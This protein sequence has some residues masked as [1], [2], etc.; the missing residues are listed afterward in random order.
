MPRQPRVRY[1]AAMHQKGSTVYSW[2]WCA[3]SW[4]PGSHALGAR[5]RGEG[6]TFPLCP[7]RWS[8]LRCAPAGVALGWHGAAP[9]RRKGAALRESEV[10]SR[11]ASG[12]ATGEGEMT[13]RVARSLSV[14]PHGDNSSGKLRRFPAGLGGR[15]GDGALSGLRTRS[16]AES[17]PLPAPFLSARISVN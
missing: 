3:I 11:A 4:F 16:A 6:P 15:A 2:L 1:P 8:R 14:P 5:G 9:P 13:L 10:G 12:R 7:G 17:L